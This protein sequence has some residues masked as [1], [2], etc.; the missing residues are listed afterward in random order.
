MFKAVSQMLCPSDGR[1][2]HI[3]ADGHRLCDGWTVAV[4]CS[5]GPTLP[6]F[7]VRR[8]QGVC[9]SSV[10][11]CMFPERGRQGGIVREREGERERE[12]G[13]ER[14]GERGRERGKSIG[15]AMKSG[16]TPAAG[17]AGQEKARQR[18]APSHR[19]RP[20][21]AMWQLLPSPGQN[22]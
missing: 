18:R 17:D 4:R 1:S 11:S 9:T 14:Q 21:A 16:C 3:A 8:W 22:S 12:R 7:L 15:A 20:S 6:G 10:Y 13:R 19:R 5:V 2:C